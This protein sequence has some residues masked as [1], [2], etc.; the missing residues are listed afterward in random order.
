M[1]VDTLK[2]AAN[3]RWPEILSAVAGI[4]AGILDGKHH[5]CPKCGGVDRFRMIDDAAGALYCNQCF[6]HDNGD[7]IAAVQWATGCDFKTACDRI[8]DHLKVG[9]AQ[10]KC[11]ASFAYRDESGKLL[12][13]IERWEPG[14]KGQRKDFKAK[15]PDG[16]FSTKG[17]RRVLYRLPELVAADVG[18]LVFIVEG[19]KH[20]DALAALG[21]T[22][23]TSPFGATA[24][25][26]DSYSESLRDRH[27]CILPDNDD[28]G[29][30]H[31]NKIA[32]A[33][34]GIAASVKRLYLP[35]L[36]P[37]GDVID[38][39][40]AGG[41]HEDLLALADSAENIGQ[42]D[43][44]PRSM[45]DR[46]A[47]RRDLHQPV[48]DGLLREGETMNMIAPP[49]TGKS[50]LV[51]NL[52]LSV[53]VGLDWLESF[54]TVRGRV[55]LIDNELHD[56]TIDNRVPKVADALKITLADYGEQLDVWTF[57]GKLKDIHSLAGDFAKLQPGQYKLVIID[58]FYRVLPPGTDENDN[59]AM[60]QIYNLIDAHAMRLKCAFV[61]IHHSS[62]GSQSDKSVIDVGSGAGAMG[63]ATDSHFVLREHEQQGVVVADAAIRSFP[64]IDPFCLKW[65]FPLWLPDETGLNPADLKRPQRRRKSATAAASEVKEKWTA[66]RFADS[67]I[68]PE[69]RPKAAIVDD[70]I[71][72]GL[73]CRQS[74]ALFGGVVAKRLAYPW[75]DKHDRRQKL[76]A[77]RPDDTPLIP[78]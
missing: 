58:S 12:Y 30:N 74:E 72:A 9:T 33:L 66:K 45:K 7:G 11:V 3:G 8:A 19:E 23:T 76:Y 70:A 46:L 77:N 34:A 10:P 16:S 41:T 17:I 50:W 53:S 43:D 28:P 44:R 63:R 78:A 73:S 27:V 37:K 42:S 1:N 64:P 31:A 68:G 49:K 24:K 5:G 57:R 4:D 21:L 61:L 13:T 38:W 15:A 25:W 47:E 62:K 36:P 2:A 20:A 52:A 40:D 71:E 51:Y 22:A 14:S 6:D 35:G 60:A 65:F 18:E 48:I 39:L 67:F 32:E 55:L 54:P 59:A 75:R 26:L 56:G 29:R 69:P